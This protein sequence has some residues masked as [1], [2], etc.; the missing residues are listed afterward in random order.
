MDS[1]KV[2]HDSR[3]LSHVLALQRASWV[4]AGFDFSKIWSVSSA[5]RE[6]VGVEV[7]PTLVTQGY[8][9]F[10]ETKTFEDIRLHVAPHQPDIL[11]CENRL[12]MHE[13]LTHPPLSELRVLIKEKRG[14]FDE[15][16]DVAFIAS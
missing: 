2:S 4:F 9:F 7:H 6:A 11:L 10:G 14:P 3:S 1:P 15:D 13:Y 8:T 5:I 12:Y 16:G